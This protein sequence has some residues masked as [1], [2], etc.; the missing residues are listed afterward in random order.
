[1]C[2]NERTLDSAPLSLNTG[3]FPRT[4][5]N[6][7]QHRFKPLKS[8][9]ELVLDSASKQTRLL[10]YFSSL[11]FTTNFFTICFQLYKQTPQYPSRFSGLPRIMHTWP[12]VL[13]YPG[14]WAAGLGLFPYQCSWNSVLIWKLRLCQGCAAQR[15]IPG[16]FWLGIVLGS[17]CAIWH[18]YCG[19]RQTKLRGS[20]EKG[21]DTSSPI[22]AHCFG[23]LSFTIT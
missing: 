7:L 4:V 2:K 6:V 12:Q 14:A 22:T 11:S 3:T 19:N 13:P 5:R 16:A 18:A 10:L 23:P 8:E 1:M 17:S 15:A 9:N 20:K 21:S